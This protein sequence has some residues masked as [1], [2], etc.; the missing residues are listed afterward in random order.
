MAKNVAT[1]PANKKRP[2]QTLPV[3]VGGHQAA[4]RAFA[5]RSKADATIRAYESDFRAFKAYCTAHGHSPL[6]AETGAVAGFLV[7]EQERG[8]QASTL[9]RRLAAIRYH[10]RL[11]GHDS[12]TDDESV[13]AV[14]SGIKRTIGTQQSPKTAATADLLGEMLKAC[15]N[16]LVGKRDR[17]MLALAF[18]G[19][20]RRS[21]LVA[22][23]VADL[24]ETPDGYRLTIRH[25][26]GDQ[27]GTGQTIAIL[28]GRRLRPVEAV[29]E[30]LSASG[31]SEGPIFRQVNKSGRLLALGRVNKHGRPVPDGLTAE[32]VAEVVKLAA[33]RAGFDPAAFAGHSLRSGFISSAAAAGASIWKMMDVSRHKSVE[34]LRRYVRDADAFRDHAGED[35]L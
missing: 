34:T 9:T 2:G 23:Q 21:E 32:T 6:P 26:K 7:G 3:V 28:R 16:T 31:I 5:R 35:F 18:A 14:L 17:A 24:A 27:E 4:A 1:R 13:R 15:P 25:S 33:Q 8:C 12:P 29:Q 10:H 19:A 30:W 11:S 20:L 22:L